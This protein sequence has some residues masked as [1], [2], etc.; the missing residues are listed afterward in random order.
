MTLGIGTALVIALLL[1]FAVAQ[2][3]SH[4]V[5]IPRSPRVGP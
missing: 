5:R 1:L 3:L 4:D 2:W